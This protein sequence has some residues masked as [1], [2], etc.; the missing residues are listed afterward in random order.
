[1]IDFRYDAE[2]LSEIRIVL[3]YRP[4][5]KL[6]SRIIYLNGKECI[7]SARPDTVMKWVGE[8]NYIDPNVARRRSEIYND[9]KRGAPLPLGIH[10]AFLPFHLV[11]ETD[12][13]R[14][15]YAYCNVANQRVE[16][17]SAPDTGRYS[18]LRTEDGTELL[19]TFTRPR[20]S[21]RV[22][23]AIATHQRFLQDIFSGGG[24]SGPVFFPPFHPEHRA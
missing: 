9:L 10:D 15:C 8:K 12:Q 20:L 4:G 5:A 2:K 3:P 21:A 23:M 24:P 17:V 16:A 14:T 6:H 1:M 18:I 19:T 7:L 22:A 13:D 11:D